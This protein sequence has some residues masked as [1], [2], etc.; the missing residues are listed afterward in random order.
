MHPL[1]EVVS[2]RSPC[3]NLGILDVGKFPD[4]P[5]R[6]SI[7][8]AIGK[9]TVM[10]VALNVVQKDIKRCGSISWIGAGTWAESLR[11]GFTP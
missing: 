10:V 9:A 5:I 11:V 8:L 3:S 2:C 4:T 6:V 1:M 7:N